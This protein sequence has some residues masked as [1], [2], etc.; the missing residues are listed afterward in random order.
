M[1]EYECIKP[2]ITDLCIDDL[3]KI[4]GEDAEIIKSRKGTY[5]RHNTL[6]L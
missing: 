5:L 1:E 6:K 3:V 4:G 2:D